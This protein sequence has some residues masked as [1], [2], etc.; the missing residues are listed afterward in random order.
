ML[1]VLADRLDGDPWLVLLMRG[2][3]REVLLETLAGGGLEASGGASQVAPWWPFAA[4]PIAVDYQSAGPLAA[5]RPGSPDAVLD[6]M[7]P[8]AVDI[9]SSTFVELLRPIYESLG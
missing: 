4:G 5:L 6:S 8:L 7:E 2:G 1:Y 3:D 9:G